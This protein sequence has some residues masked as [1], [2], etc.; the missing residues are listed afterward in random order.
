MERPLDVA[1]LAEYLGVSESWVY[2]QTA[3]RRIPHTRVGREIR[4]TPEHVQQI[5][6]AGDQPAISAPPVVTHIRRP[7]HRTPRAA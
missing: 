6:A 7:R 3:R 5:L 1:G 2:K 4:F